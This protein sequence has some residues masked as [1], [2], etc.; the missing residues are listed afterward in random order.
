MPYVYLTITV[1]VGSNFM[2]KKIWI[3][4][5]VILSGFTIVVFLFIPKELDIA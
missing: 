4:M 1:R 2:W 3:I 5:L